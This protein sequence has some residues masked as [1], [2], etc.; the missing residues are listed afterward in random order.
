MKCVPESGF[1]YC[2]RCGHRS[3]LS[4][5]CIEVLGIAPKEAKALPISPT[6]E[7]LQKMM[8]P[9]EPIEVLKDQRPVAFRLLPN[10]PKTRFQR[11]VYDYLEKRGWSFEMI[12]Q[13]GVGY[14]LDKTLAGRIIFPI[15]Y[16]DT[17]VY[18]QARTMD[19]EEQPKYKNPYVSKEGIIYGMEWINPRKKV[20]LVEG[21]FDTPGMNAG[22][23]LGKRL[24]EGKIL[25]LIAAGVKKV[26]LYLDGSADVTDA[27]IVN[28]SKALLRNGMTCEVAFCSAK[29]PGEA[30]S[31]QKAHDLRNAVNVLDRLDLLKLRLLLAGA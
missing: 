24:T 26:V 16:G 15:Y 7:Q 2:F 21:L 19:D 31:R 10:V 4:E 27:D 11:E 28:N 17:M 20:V 5:L 22:A 23:L 25:R 3:S 30:T 29:D 12:H 9:D 13:R 14:S 1:A 18:W 6:I 8:S